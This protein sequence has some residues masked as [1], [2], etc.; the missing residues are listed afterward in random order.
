MRIEEITRW[1]AL[2]KSSLVLGLVRGKTR[3]ADPRLHLNDLQEAHGEVMLKRR[4]QTT[5]IERYLGKGVR[6][7]PEAGM[8]RLG[9][10]YEASTR[11]GG[12]FTAMRIIQ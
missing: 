9:L 1:K 3:T 5:A 2:R 8:I 10:R 7:R 12:L 4:L 11:L 6:F